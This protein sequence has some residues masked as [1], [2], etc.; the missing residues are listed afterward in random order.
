MVAALSAILILPWWSFFFDL[1]PKAIVI[2]VGAALVLGAIPAAV[3]TLRSLNAHDAMA[4]NPLVR[5]S[6]R[7]HLHFGVLLALGCLSALF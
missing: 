4:L 5:S 3:I 6:A 2:L 1:I 7:L